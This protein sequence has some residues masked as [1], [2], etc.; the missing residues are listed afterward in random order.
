[1]VSQIFINLPVAD[2]GASIAFFT[3]LGFTFNPEFSDDT[4][5]CMIVGDNIF[6]MLLA[7][8]RFAEFTPLPLSD[9]HTVTEVLVALRLQSREAVDVMVREAVA[10]GGSIYNDSQDYGFMYSHGFQDPDGHIWEVMYMTGAPG[11]AA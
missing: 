10:A 2:L 7:R 8:E 11:G 5:T 1:M 9:A 3:R 4:A 6:A